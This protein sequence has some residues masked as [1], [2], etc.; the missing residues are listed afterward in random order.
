VHKRRAVFLDR[1]GVINVNRSDHVKS[2]EEFVFLPRSLDAL[3]KIAASD[4]FAIV[5]TNQAAIN[6]NL[7]EDATVRDIHNRME[8]AI[9]HAGGCLQAIYYCPHRPDENCDCRKPRPG[10]YLQAA[11]EF[12]LDLAASYVIGDTMADVNAARAIEAQPILVL[13]GRGSADGLEDCITLRDLDEAVEWILQK[14]RGT[15]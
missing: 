13:S 4:F 6:R 1:D 15:A 7:V 9:E 2:W 8:A 5:T 10:M 3:R 12:N 14:E 11:R